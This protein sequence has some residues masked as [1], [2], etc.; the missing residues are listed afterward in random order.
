M[1]AVVEILGKQYKAEKGATLRVDHIEGEAGKKLEFSNVLFLRG[2][3]DTDL[4]SPYVKGA[5]VTAEIEEHKKGDKVIVF[6]YKRRKDYQRKQGH[7]QQYT[8][9][10][11]KD[12]VKG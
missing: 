8:V 2:E 12:I 3:K 1:Y 7:R 10:R 11:V 9:I 6:K 4:G 5:K